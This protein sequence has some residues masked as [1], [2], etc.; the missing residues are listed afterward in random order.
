MKYDREKMAHWLVGWRQLYQPLMNWRKSRNEDRSLSLIRGL[1]FLRLLT[2]RMIRGR[3]G[4]P[5]N[6]L[7]E[8]R[9][10]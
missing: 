8:S 4:C 5:D 1:S 7:M 2:T 6:N 9:I 10:S 3:L